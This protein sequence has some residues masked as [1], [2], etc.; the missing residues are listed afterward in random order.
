MNTIPVIDLQAAHAEL[1]EELEAAAIAV[2]RSGWYVLGEQVNRFEAEFAAWLGLPADAAVGVNSGTDALHL[3]LRACG[4]GPGHE[5]IVPSHTAVATAAAVEMAGAVPVFADIHPDTY[6]LDPARAAEVVGPRTKAIVAVHL[7]G[8]AAD[9][10]GLSA[11]AADRGLWLIE[12]CAQAHG[13][14]WQGRPVGTVGDVGCFSFYPTKNLGAAGDGGLVVSRHPEIA[15]QARL[16][17]QYGWRERYVSDVAGVNS[18]LDEL[19][20][21]LLRVKLRHLDRWNRQRQALARLYDALL[22]EADVVR[23]AVA[24]GNEHV[25]HLYVVRSR[26]RDALRSHLARR[27]I[28]T[29]I[30]YPVPV[31]Q[32]PAYRRLA[33]AG[34]LPVTERAAAEVL[35]LPMYPQLAP[36][37][38]KRVAEGIREFVSS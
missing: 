3:A 1:A 20:A 37:A 19:Q 8:Q 32:Q 4:V 22:A 13:A 25:Y 16:L 38:V 26:Q 6:T 23:P 21:A 11:L 34:G 2:L 31:H 35:S 7:Y 24:A 9:L 36:A 15:E 27:G 28:A 30:H 18:R 33:P 12:D 14:R 29:A 10:G 17:R 5:V